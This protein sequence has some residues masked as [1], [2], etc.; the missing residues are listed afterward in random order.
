VHD[1]ADEDFFRFDLTDPGTENDRIGLIKVTQSDDLRLQILHEDGDPV[2]DDVELAVLPRT[3]SLDGLAAGRYYLRVYSPL[4]AGPARY[5]LV[6]QVGVPVPQTDDEDDRDYVGTAVLDLSGKQESTLEIFDLPAGEYLL[7]VLSPGR[8]ADRA[9][10]A[11]DRREEPEVE[12]FD[13]H[14]IVRRDVILGGMGNDRLAAARA[15]L[16]SARRATSLRR[17][18]PPGRGLALAATATTLS[19]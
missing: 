6:S 1:G 16:I 17:L 15:R 19:S 10:H 13:A 4:Q 9:T 3:V 2:V 14:E 7:K 12:K 5:E 8:R 11:A 18:R